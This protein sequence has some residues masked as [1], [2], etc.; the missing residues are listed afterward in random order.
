MRNVGL[1]VVLVAAELSGGARA[2]P[3]SAP[4]Q[5]CGAQAVR[6]PVGRDRHGLRALPA[7]PWRS[8]T[9]LLNQ[10]C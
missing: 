1:R 9:S 7:T 8:S 5:Q 10:T 2:A 3:V 4:T 6:Q